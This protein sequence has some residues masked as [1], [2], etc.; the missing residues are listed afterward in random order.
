MEFMFWLMPISFVFWIVVALASKSRGTK[1]TIRDFENKGR[2]DVD[3]HRIKTVVE[4]KPPLPKVSRSHGNSKNKNA[5]PYFP[6]DWE[7]EVFEDWD[8]DEPV[9]DGYSEEPSDV[10]GSDYAINYLDRIPQAVSSISETFRGRGMQKAASNWVGLYKTM[11]RPRGREIPTFAVFVPEEGNPWD[12]T[13]VSIVVHGRHIAYVPAELSSE[14]KRF[15]IANGGL[16][17]V[18]VVLWFDPG[19]TKNTVRVH[20]AKPYRMKD[21]FRTNLKVRRWTSPRWGSKLIGFVN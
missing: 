12:P 14:V 10:F 6:E 7:D 18:E 15:V 20:L 4:P 16:V 5:S 17:K 1:T 21:N 3:S 2:E 11:K 13:A 19:R 8:D 9:E